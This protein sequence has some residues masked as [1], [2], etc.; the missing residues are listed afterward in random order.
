MVREGK[1]ATWSVITEIM[2]EEPYCEEETSALAPTGF[3]SGAGTDL[4]LYN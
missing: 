1:D 3:K 2:V 4:P